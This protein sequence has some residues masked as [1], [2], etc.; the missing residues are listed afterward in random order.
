MAGVLAFS[1]WGAL[2]I[3]FIVAEGVS[4]IE[5]LLHRVVWAVPFGALIIFARR[6][7]PDVKA[8]FTNRRTF[9][10]LVLSAVF[11]S[12]NWLVYIWASQHGFIFQASLGYYINPLMWILVGFVLFG[13][14]LRR[15]QIGAVI[16]A[17][18]GVAVLTLSGGQFPLISITLAVTFT[19]YGVIRKQVAVGAMPGLF[20]ELLVLFPMSAI[21][22]GMLVNGDASPF[23]WND[24]G[25][26]G[27]LLLAGPITVLP[28]V[29]FAFAARRLP[30]ATLGFLQFIGP[31]GQFFVGYY[32]GEPLTQAHL[33]CFGFIWTAVLLFV[34]DSVW[35]SRQMKDTK[36][37]TQL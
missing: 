4:A 3:Y 31:T 37:R 25:M 33:I 24:R 34:I 36:L 7:W 16:L 23:T 5:M 6:Q 20:V 28:L 8:A 11:I 9:G 26:M 29:F 19:L 17:T 10:F 21:V 35:M 12:I 2:P 18:I 1:M 22:L 27:L 32:N 30:L 14:Q 15:F 13:E